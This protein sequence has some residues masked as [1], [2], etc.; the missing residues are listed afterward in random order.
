MR[1]ATDEQK[2]L[3]GGRSA[4]D[5]AKYIYIPSPDGKGLI[6]I[7][8]PEQFGAITGLAYLWVVG[9]Y[10][11]NKATFNNYMDV[12]EAAIPD[13]VNILK[14]KQMVLSWIPHAL[15][16][17]VDVAV[18][19]K[20]FPEILPIV[21]ESMK[22]LPKE[23]QYTAYTSRLAKFLGQTFNASPMLID[24]WIKNQ[25]GAA[26]QFLLGSTPN[27]PIYV[28]EGQYVLSGRAY[29][30]FYDGRDSAEERYQMTKLHPDRFS[31]E[32]VEAVKETRKLYNDIADYLKDARTVSRNQNLPE[33]VKQ[34]TYELLI[35]LEDGEH[36]DH[37]RGKIGKLREVVDPL[38]PEKE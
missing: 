2:R 8:I 1:F 28:Q 30:H 25:F 14:P 3:L 24:Y 5:L 18:N 10:G 36:E 11:G 22:D 4:K 12:L 29:N 31:E 35:M 15:K 33:S 7:R 27:L 21:P 38:L 6:R 34:G 37:I 17:S 26:S 32:E 9:N 23:E 19:T 20:D 13:Q 16:P